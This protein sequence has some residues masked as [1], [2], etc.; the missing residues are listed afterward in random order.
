MVRAEGLLADG[1]HALEHLLG[2]LVAPSRLQQTGHVAEAGRHVRVVSAEGFLE[3]RLRAPMQLRRLL[4]AA[5]R[6]W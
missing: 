1:E 2:F 5:L 6:C 3:D 4:V